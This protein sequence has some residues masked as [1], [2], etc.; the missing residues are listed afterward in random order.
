M[1]LHLLVALWSCLSAG[2]GRYTLP[3]AGVVDPAEGVSFRFKDHF[4]VLSARMQVG[5]GVMAQRG[6][7]TNADLDTL[8]NWYNTRRQYVEIV[9]QDNALKPRT[10]IALGFE[11][12]EHNGE[13]PY[14]PAHAV[15]QVKNFSWGGIEFSGIDT[16]NYTGISNHIS[17]DFSI[18]INGF[19]NDTIY[20]HFSGLLLSGGG[21]MASI[22]EGYFRVRVYR[23]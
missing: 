5:Q 4:Y 19:A 2:P 10:G 16:L 22:E 1:L 14:T 7:L 13:Y 17:D 18:E 23:K 15:L 3:T 6:G 12:D 9:R 20:G 8:S 21:A 11:F